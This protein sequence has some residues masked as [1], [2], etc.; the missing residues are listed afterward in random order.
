M[1]RR[2]LLQDTLKLVG[3]HSYGREKGATWKR[4]RSG[5][6]AAVG[7]EFQRPDS[8]RPTGR[9]GDI[10]EQNLGQG[11]LNRVTGKERT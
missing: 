2:C 10:S 1:R 8:R 7:G 3:G 9:G 11:S 6:G 4:G 5:Q